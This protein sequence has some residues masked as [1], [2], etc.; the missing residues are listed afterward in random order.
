VLVLPRAGSIFT[1]ECV[2]GRRAKSK[3]RA[4]RLG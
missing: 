4:S 3:V 2:T 1:L